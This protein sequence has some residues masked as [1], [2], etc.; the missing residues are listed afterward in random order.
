MDIAKLIHPDALN[1]PQAQAILANPPADPTPLPPNPNLAKANLEQS[2]VMSWLRATDLTLIHPDSHSIDQFIDL[3]TDQ[4]LT[5]FEKDDK[6]TLAVDTETTGLANKAYLI[7]GSRIAHNQIVGFSLATSSKTAYYLPVAHNGL[8]NIKNYTLEDIRKLILHLQEEYYL[9]WHNALYD[10]GI[11]SS[12]GIYLNKTAHRCSQIL[13]FHL[14]VE[15]IDNQRSLGLKQLSERYLNRKMLEINEILLQDSKKNIHF[16][17]LCASD[18]L[19]YAASDAL[20]T[21]AL[22]EKAY[23]DKEFRKRNIALYSPFSFKTQMYANYNTLALTDHGMPV[24][25]EPLKNRLLELQMELIYYKKRIDNFFKVDSGSSA[26]LGVAIADLLKEAWI[27][28]KRDESQFEEYINSRFH[29]TRK[30][31]KLKSGGISVSYPSND[32]VLSALTDERSLSFMGDERP[33]FI[34]IIKD[35]QHFRSLDHLIQI[36][37]SYY[38]QLTRDDRGTYLPFNLRINGAYTGRYSNGGWN[39]ERVKVDLTRKKLSYQI[40]SSSIMPNMQGI[41]GAM[42]DYKK[43]TPTTPPAELLTQVEELQLE[44]RNA[45][46][47]RMLTL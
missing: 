4:D 28:S 11:L 3:I 45:I 9:V 44:A 27:R 1:T 2:K 47:E 16:E 37:H 43:L 35:I 39:Y 6:P 30:E 26:K 38:R 15:E 10:M 40:T 25:E 20:N 12:N 23:T 5:T 21:F 24:Q 17:T 18:A 22:W 46:T 36:F 42:P 13:Y 32:E 29:L 19:V 33:S 34:Q 8:D 14:G 41:S 31:T 7:N